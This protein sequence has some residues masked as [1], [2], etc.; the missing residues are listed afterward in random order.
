VDVELE[1]GEE[2]KDEGECTPT[3]CWGYE[4]VE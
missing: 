1:G 3:E 2:M 4:D